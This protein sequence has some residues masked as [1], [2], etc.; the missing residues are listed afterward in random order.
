MRYLFSLFLVAA[1]CLISQLHA[2]EKADR[3]NESN[4]HLRQIAQW[5]LMYANDNRGWT[6]ASIEQ[7]SPY[8]KDANNESVF[9]K[10]IVN[11]RTGASPGYKLVLEQSRLTKIRNVALTPLLK[12]VDKS[13]EIPADTS[14][15]M[16]DGHVESPAARQLRSQA[17]SRRSDRVD[18]ARNSTKMPL[19]HSVCSPQ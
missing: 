6:P 18:E 10:V 1:L 9:D 3:R 5:A 19:V 14:V 4:S 8:A 13:G 15:A 2:D 11:P 17:L 12:E 16:C 7:L